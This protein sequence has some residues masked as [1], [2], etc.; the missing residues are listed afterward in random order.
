MEYCL[1]V[2][3]WT[4]IVFPLRNILAKTLCAQ[5]CEYSCSVPSSIPSFFVSFLFRLFTYFSFLATP[6]RPLIQELQ[7]NYYF[8]M[9]KQTALHDPDAHP[10][11]PY[12]ARE[13]PICCVGIDGE[14]PGGA[15]RAPSAL[16][17][18]PEQEPPVLPPPPSAPPEPQALRTIRGSS[19]ASPDRVAGFTDRRGR[20]KAKGSSAT[21]EGGDV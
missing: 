6:F 16:L 3:K 13:F 17:V 18:P 4:R 12:F 2:R 7:S 11:A 8:W 19:S 5:T 15:T 10:V 9:E 1:A 14:P 20:D 21:Q